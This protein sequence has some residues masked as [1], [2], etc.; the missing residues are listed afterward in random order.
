[1]T[2]NGKNGTSEWRESHQE[3]EATDAERAWRTQEEAWASGPDWQA[4]AEFCYLGT[5][6]PTP[7]ALKEG[8]AHLRAA[9]ERGHILAQHWLATELHMGQGRLGL[10]ED[11]AEAAAWYA[12]AARNGHP[13]AVMHLAMLYAAHPEAPREH[14]AARQYLDALLR[15]TGASVP[16]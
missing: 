6:R 15:R 16:A 9:A 12:V 1:M 11:A 8:I 7:K 3:P 14:D 2:I 10:A 13:A 5:G 4:F